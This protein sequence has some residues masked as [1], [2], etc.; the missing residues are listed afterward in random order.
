M[1]KKDIDHIQAILIHKLPWVDKKIATTL[2][3]QL[4]YNPIKPV[5]ETKNFYRFRLREP[6]EFNHFVT[7][8]YGNLVSM[9]I[10]YE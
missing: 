5:H 3:K 2:V 8:N 6:S 1:P 7:R 9:I 10:G 4:G